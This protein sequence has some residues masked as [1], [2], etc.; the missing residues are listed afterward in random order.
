MTTIPKLWRFTTLPEAALQALLVTHQ[1]KG[2]AAYRQARAT[3]R[4]L[5][6]EGNIFSL[7]QEDGGQG[8]LPTPTTQ[9]AGVLWC[10]DDYEERVA[11]KSLRRF[12]DRVTIED[13]RAGLIKPR[14]EKSKADQQRRVKAKAEVFTPLWVC[15]TQNNLVDEALLG[16]HL[17]NTVAE[18]DPKAWVPTEG[19]IIFPESYPWTR[20][21]TDRRLEMACGE[22]P[23]LMSPY[24][25]TT[26]AYLPVRDDQGRFQRIGLL[27]R[28]LRVVSEHMTTSEE[29]QQAALMALSSIYGY[30]WQGDN[31][32]LA[33]LNMVNTYFDYLQDFHKAHN[34]PTLSKAELENLVVRVAQEAAW[35]LWQMDGLKQVVPETCTKACKAC[36]KRQRK[37][38]NGRVPA[39]RWGSTLKAFE[40]FLD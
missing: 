3:A 17:F 34:L 7:F 30:E 28:K 21:V 23:Y 24:D 35:Q 22:A 12:K 33:R 40:D 27:D 8:K 16:S 26:G 29:W 20:Y 5:G 38:H 10:A 37:G 9:E 6:E 18:E 36:P 25:A 32:L 15:N 1:V 13:L 31:L 39:L 2:A 11:G 4:S 19:T 14:V